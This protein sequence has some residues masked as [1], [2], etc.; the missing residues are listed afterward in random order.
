MKIQQQVEV[1]KAYR[2]GSY[3]SYGSRVLVTVTAIRLNETAW[4]DDHQEGGWESKGMVE[5]VDGNGTIG[6]QCL[7]YAKDNWDAAK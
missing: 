1:G 2:L 5:W 3:E 7:E 4:Y 6:W